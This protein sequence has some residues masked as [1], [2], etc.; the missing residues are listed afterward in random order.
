[1]KTRLP[2]YGAAILGLAL[3]IIF[4]RNFPYAWLVGGTGLLFGMYVELKI[5]APCKYLDLLLLSC[6]SDRKKL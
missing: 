6:I 3:Y 2:I 1:M 4:R 5:S